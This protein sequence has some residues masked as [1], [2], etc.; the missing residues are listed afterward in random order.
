MTS[1][2]DAMTTF[3]YL[4]AGD[5]RHCLRSLADNSIDAVVTD[6]PY[7]LGREPDMAEVLRHW[8]A[9]DDYAASGGGFMG[10]TWDSFVPGP[11]TWREVYRVLKPGGHVVMFSGTR[12]WDIATLALRLAGFEIR[13]GLMWLYGSGFPKSL[14]VSKA[15]DKAAGAEREVVGSKAGQ[16]GYS[17][18]DSRPEGHAIYGRGLGGSGD[19]VKEPD[20]TAPATPEADQWDGWGT[21]LKPAWEPIV[22]ARKPLIGTVVSNVLKHG[23]GA[24]NI[25]ASR[26]GSRFPAN[27]ILSHAEDCELVGVKTVVSGT[28][29]S[30]RTDGPSTPA[31][32]G[33]WKARAGSSIGE[34]S[35][36]VYDCAPD[37]P[38]ALLD[39]QSGTLKSGKAAIDGHKRTQTNMDNASE[40]E[41]LVFGGGKGIAG[42][43]STSDAGVLYGDSGGASR[44]FY[45]AKVAK[46]ERNRG[47]PEG[48]KNDHPTVKPV[49]LMEYLV[50]LV[51]PPDGTVLDPFCGSGATGIASHTQGFSFVGIDQDPRSIY[52]SRHRISYYG[53]DVLWDDDNYVSEEAT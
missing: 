41:H 17:L 3:S 6:P 51:T 53:A 37:C 22:L 31:W 28:Q 7:G 45:S 48:E 20:I 42:T 38:V 44:F 15:I 39:E 33:A 50:K 11:A 46:K 16:P 19:P 24:I 43:S 10:K 32:D 2:M 47:M 27:L 18:A 25:D 23:T 12:T 30:G 35:V 4:M 40:S 1:D 49:A 52:I 5:N 9:G 36:D 29:T 8:L 14:N 34:E 13:D 26:I 21:A